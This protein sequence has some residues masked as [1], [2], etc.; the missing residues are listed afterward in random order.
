MRGA[1]DPDVRGL[2][3]DDVDERRPRAKPRPQRVELAQRIG[4]GRLRGL[5]VPEKVIPLVPASAAMP[6]T[7]TTTPV[8]VTFTHV[9][10]LDGILARA[11]VFAV[12]VDSSPSF[13]RH[14]S[15]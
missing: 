5:E 8:M 12:L 4:L 7:A 9:R 3:V 13:R 1:V 6:R 2:E 14:A 15:V 11:A 10:M